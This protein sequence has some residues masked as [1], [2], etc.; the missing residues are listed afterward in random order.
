MNMPLAAINH[1]EIAKQSFMPELVTTFGETPA[2]MTSDL[3][4]NCCEPSQI[5]DQHFAL[6][7]GSHKDVK[8]YVVYFCHIMAFFADGTHCGLA[9]PKQFVAFL[10]CKETPESIVLK[11]NN[12]HIEL[13]LNTSAKI[14]KGESATHIELPA[15]ST[16]TSKS[17]DDYF[18]E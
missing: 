10:G 7:N 13:V 12:V 2:H 3:I 17:G 1:F 6:Q 18:V 11:E 5:L 9:Q 8:Q 4:N 16:F 15:Q 14:N